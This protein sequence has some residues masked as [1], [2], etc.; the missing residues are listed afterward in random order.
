MKWRHSGSPRSKIFRV[1]KFFGKLLVAIFW[2]QDGFIFID[3]LPKGQ[4]IMRSISHLSWR[5]LRK[6]WR[7]NNLGSSPNMSW[8]CTLR[9]CSSWPGTCNPEE[10]GLPGLPKSSSP[11]LFSGSGPIG[12]PP[13]NWT[14]KELMDRHFS[15]DTDFIAA[16]ETLMCGQIS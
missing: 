8:S 9:K 7:K 13:V 5:N 6:F 16:L 1:Q 3:Y 11:L 12:L 15:S 14:E 4:T 2:V 10:T